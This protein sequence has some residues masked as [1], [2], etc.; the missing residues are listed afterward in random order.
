MA[1]YLLEDVRS[2]DD[3]LRLKNSEAVEEILQYLPPQ[4]STPKLQV[5]LIDQCEILVE[6]RDGLVYEGRRNYKLQEGVG[7]A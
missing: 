2:E 4:T 5:V 6:V 7:C 3:D 1:L